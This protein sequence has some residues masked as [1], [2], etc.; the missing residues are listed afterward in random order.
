ML[1]E[2]LAKPGTPNDPFRYRRWFSDEDFSLA[3]YYG[4][5]NQIIAF[6]LVYDW[7]QKPIC[8]RWSQERGSNHYRMDSGD[9][10]P[11]SNMTPIL[12]RKVEPDESYRN[13]FASAA[14][15]IDDEIRFLILRQWQ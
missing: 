11:Q 1:R 15:K 6:D 14:A 13:L 8:L 10:S 2:H 4:N 9:D 7:L 12:T 3:V 5:D